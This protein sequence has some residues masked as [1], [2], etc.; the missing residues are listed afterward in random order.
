MRFNV[1]GLD[2][3]GRI[4]ARIEHGLDIVDDLVEES[5]QIMAE[6]AEGII[7]QS[8]RE[9]HPAGDFMANRTKIEKNL[10]GNT[11]I[12]RISGKKEGEV[13]NPE[14][15]D[16][17]VPK[18]SNPNRVSLWE[19]LEYGRDS[20]GG[21][22]DITYIKDEGTGKKAIRSGRS[23]GKG[24]QY[25][26]MVEDIITGLTLQLDAAFEEFGAIAAHG[27]TAA[28][29]KTA[30]VK[31]DASAEAALRRAGISRGTLKELGV[32]R[33]SVSSSGQINLIG[34]GPGGK[35]TATFIS[36]SGVGVP[37]TIG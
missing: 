26:G 17:T 21:S 1:Q 16:G 12:F 2:E 15:R 4:V 36:G 37:T 29:M 3:A 9:L 32:T 6:A 7:V 23:H 22:E 27:T 10:L 19:V 34:P 25:A 20:D 11:I 18:V 35:G 8:I 33:V 24:G 13:E 30:G 28:M 14:R 31:V 5:M